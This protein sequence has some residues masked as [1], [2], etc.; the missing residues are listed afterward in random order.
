MAALASAKSATL[1]A[2]QADVGD[3]GLNSPPANT[4]NCCTDVSQQLVDN[5]PI[6]IHFQA[7]DC[8]PSSRLQ[9]FV[10][11]RDALAKLLS[12]WVGKSLTSNDPPGYD[13]WRLVKLIR[14]VDPIDS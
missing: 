13:L 7:A 5:A 14:L 6:L 1:D 9:R 11:H 12:E 4:Y 8:Q 3:N 10:E 2:R